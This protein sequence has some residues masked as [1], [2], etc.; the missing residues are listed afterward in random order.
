MRQGIMRR[1][2][3]GRAGLGITAVGAALVFTLF[4]GGAAGAAPAPEAEAAP[5]AAAEANPQCEAIGSV[6]TLAG[7]N[8][9]REPNT[10][11]TIDGIIP[12]GV[13][14]P[15]CGI[16]EGGPYSVCGVQGW[17]YW[18]HVNWNGQS[19]YVAGACTTLDE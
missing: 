2:M 5:A 19:G 9:R 15:W 16:V 7:V 10:N 12:Q 4:S 8:L 3:A 14:V 11:A 18:D 1:G 6:T 17:T 13:S